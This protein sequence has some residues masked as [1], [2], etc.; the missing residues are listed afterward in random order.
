MRTAR[1]PVQHS[2][3]ESGM[4]MMMVRFG[5]LMFGVL[6]VRV[7]MQMTR[8]VVFMLVSVHRKRF[9]QSPDP[10]AQQHD[11]HHSLAP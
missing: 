3:A 5:L 7:H 11:P 1:H 10:D 6:P 2:N 8:A 4:R 9:A